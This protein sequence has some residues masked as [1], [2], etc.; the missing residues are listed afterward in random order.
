MSPASLLHLPLTHMTGLLLLALVLGGLIG[1]E[2]ERH[3]RPAG[4]RTHILVCLGSTLITLAGNSAGSASGGRIAAQIVTGVGFLGAGTIIRDGTSGSVRGLTT[5]A[6]LWA[7]AGVGIAVGYGGLYAGL[8]TVGTLI[9]LFTLTLLNTFEDALIRQRRRHEV[10]VVLRLDSDPLRSLS[11]LLDTLREKGTP[12]RD[13]KLT[14]LVETGT[15]RFQI[16]LS[17]YVG[18]DAV[19]ALLGNVPGVV[20]Y[21]WVD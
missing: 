20:H 21:E 5:A 8:A 18:R 12:A 7:I 9:I 10:L 13:L 19:D 2:R 14:R 16:T 17:R 11:T 15:A 4:L 6:S 3:E 1:W